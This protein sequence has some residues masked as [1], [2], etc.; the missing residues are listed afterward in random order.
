MIVATRVRLLKGSISYFQIFFQAIAFL[1]TVASGY[2]FL[3]F[4]KQQK[5]SG[6]LIKYCFKCFVRT[7][8]TLKLHADSNRIL[9]P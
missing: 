8:S 9:N 2:I 1:R 5:L 3:S 7:V 4:G 6:L